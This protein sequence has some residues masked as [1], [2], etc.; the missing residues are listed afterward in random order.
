MSRDELF[1]DAFVRG[2]HEAGDM[3]DEES[4][5][6]WFYRLLRNAVFDHYRHS[7]AG[8]KAMEAQ[9]HET[10]EFDPGFDAADLERTVCDRASTTSFVSSSQSIPTAWETCSDYLVI[11]TGS[12]SRRRRARGGFAKNRAVQQ[13]PSTL[14]A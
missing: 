6:A 14:L 12:L 3:L 5:V 1:H 7:A 8:C 2:L 10:P 9:S 11:V 4:A 13:M